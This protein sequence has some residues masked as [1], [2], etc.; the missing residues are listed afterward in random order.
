MGGSELVR[1]FASTARQSE[2]ERKPKGIAS[3]CSK[4]RFRFK[5]YRKGWEKRW[6]S[7]VKDLWQKILFWQFFKINYIAVSHSL[8][9]QVSWIEL[10][11]TGLYLAWLAANAGCYAS[12]GS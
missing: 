9:P 1:E 2:G 6:E 3:V 12:D 7:P 8:F 10:Q 5:V 4:S 11:V